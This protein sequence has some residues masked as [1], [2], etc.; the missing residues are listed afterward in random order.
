M[1]LSTILPLVATVASI[2]VHALPVRV[3]STVQHDVSLTV[4]SQLMTVA[5]YPTN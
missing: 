4:V 2:S 3:S 5:G 1:K